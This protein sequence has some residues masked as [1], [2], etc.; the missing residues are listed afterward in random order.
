MNLCLV[1][2]VLKDAGA[3]SGH[4]LQWWCL[5]RVLQTPWVL[6]GTSGQGPLMNRTVLCPAP[7][8][9]FHPGNCFSPFCILCPSQKFLEDRTLLKRNKQNILVTI[10]LLCIL[11]WIPDSSHWR[12]ITSSNSLNS[13]G[14]GGFFF[15]FEHLFCWI[16]M[17]N[18]RR[19]GVFKDVFIGERHNT[20]ESPNLPGEDC[21]LRWLLL[22]LLF[23]HFT[24]EF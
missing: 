17:L 13:I 6:D 10:G 15:F 12:S 2:P 20:T 18:W 7:F 8:P 16:L 9:S 1:C 19:E 22:V 23:E 5:D 4:P 3:D 14:P 24:F 11:T 21:S